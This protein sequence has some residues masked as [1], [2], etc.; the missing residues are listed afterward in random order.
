M[1]FLCVKGLVRHKP[2]LKSNSQTHN[3]DNPLRLA[4]AF[5][6]SWNHSKQVALGYKTNAHDGFVVFFNKSAFTTKIVHS[7]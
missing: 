1:S 2:E 5:P 4:V 7:E 3:L 6:Q